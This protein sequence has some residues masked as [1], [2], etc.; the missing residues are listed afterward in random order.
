MFFKRKYD[1]IRKLLLDNKIESPK[2][3][4]EKQWNQEIDEI[5]Q[6]IDTCELEEDDRK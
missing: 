3:E 6:I 4:E 5:I 1:S 2:T